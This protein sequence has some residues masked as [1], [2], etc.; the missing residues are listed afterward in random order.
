MALMKSGKIRSASGVLPVDQDKF[1][2][3]KVPDQKAPLER[4]PR[5]Q[6]CISR[7]Y[8]PW[9]R[10]PHVQPPPPEADRTRSGTLLASFSKIARRT[11]AICSTYVDH[12]SSPENRNAEQPLRLPAPNQLPIARRQRR[13]QPDGRSVVVVNVHSEQIWHGRPAFTHSLMELAPRLP[14]R[15]VGFSNQPGTHRAGHIA[16]QQFANGS[17]CILLRQRFCRSTPKLRGARSNRANADRSA[18]QAT[19]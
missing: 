18:R 17:E 7:L 11:P 3:V 1:E 8:N 14:M 19:R 12:V 10:S 4:N 5:Q 2:H 15:R 13:G 9:P 16:A 6:P